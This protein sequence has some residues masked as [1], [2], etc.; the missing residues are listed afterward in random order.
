[1]TDPSL[2]AC[3]ALV[4][5]HDPDRY[6]SA[7]F[8]PAAKRPYLFALY[9]FNY[10]IARVAERVNEPML[11]EMRLEWWREMVESARN[12]EPIAHDVA[13]GLA[14]LFAAVELP[15]TEID[16]M[17]DARAVHTGAEPIADIDALERYADATSGALMRLALRIMGAGDAHNDLAREAGIAYAL[18]GLLRALPV[19]AAQQR[20]YL[21]DT[22]LGEFKLTREE[23]F[24]GRGA[25]K[26]VGAMRWL[27]E[28][29][30]SRLISARRRPRPKKCVA[31]VLPATLVPLYLKPIF[32]RGFDPFRWRIEVPVAR[33]QWAL[34][35]SALRGKI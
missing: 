25:E 22:L 30:Q 35:H 29:A 12:S 18:A 20:L 1:M 27:A 8:A 24:A 6:Y 14:V 5:A 10:E 13:R 28:R 21:P 26:L 33:R 17:L 2:A 32:K 23:I 31:A 34:L 7:L 16:A 9:A 11:G 4:R 19:H 15:Q 3:E